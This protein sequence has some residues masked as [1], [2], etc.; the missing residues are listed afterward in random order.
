LLYRPPTRLAGLRTKLI[1]GSLSPI[2]LCCAC[3]GI[4]PFVS[5]VSQALGTVGSYVI[6]VLG[7]VV[8][9]GFTVAGIRH[10]WWK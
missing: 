5:M 9:I 10:R 7:V 3:Q 1:A 2:L 4:V 8:G 6:G